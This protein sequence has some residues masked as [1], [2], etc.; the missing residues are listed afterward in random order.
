MRSG[1][2]RLGPALTVCLLAWG[3]AAAVAKYDTAEVVLHSGQVFD[4]ISGT[5]NP[6]TTVV[7]TLS[8]TAP[9]GRTCAACDRPASPDPSR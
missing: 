3:V 2:L 6:F 9:D 8:V 5:P 7:L 4:G 1:L